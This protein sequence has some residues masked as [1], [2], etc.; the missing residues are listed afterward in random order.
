VPLPV[1][2]ERFCWSLTAIRRPCW[3]S[4]DAGI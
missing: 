4:R 3:R 1:L 2:L